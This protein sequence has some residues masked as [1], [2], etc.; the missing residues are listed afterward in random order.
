MR[1]TIIKKDYFHLKV[2][3]D[4]YWLLLKSLFLR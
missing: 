1:E 3:L 2:Y 4:A